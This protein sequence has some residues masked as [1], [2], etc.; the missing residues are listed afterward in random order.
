[1]ALAGTVTFKSLGDL[2]PDGENPRLRHDQRGTMSDD[3]LLEYVAATYEPIVVAES[4]ARHGF[5]GSEPLIV[6]EE[7]GRQIVL[8]GNRR[9]TALLGLARPELRARFDRPHEW[10]ELANRR[11]ISLDMSI[12]VLEA[13]AREDADAVIGFRH[14]SGVEQWKPLQ[15]AQYVAYLVDVRGKPFLEVADTVGE[16]EDVIRMYYRNQ[17][18]L[19]KAREL[20]HDD[21]ADA[22]EQRFGT[23]T[24]ALNRTGIREFIGARVVGAVQ[25]GQQQL[26]QDKLDAFA[27]LSSWLYGVDGREKIISDTRNLTELAEVLRA[28]DALEELRRSRDLTSAYAL[29]PGPPKRLLKQ[30]AIAVGHLRSVAN[31]AELIVGEARTEELVDELDERSREIVRV[32]RDAEPVDE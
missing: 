5:F 24:A 23:F 4:I 14:I 27:E 10:E 15:R 3:E 9:L 7:N 17:S 21:L 8:E 18:I 11:P 31:S 16:E 30:L 22:S 25:E 28:P 26:G 29:T 13:D 1:M 20:G 2:H 19:E 12:P 6:T 32:V